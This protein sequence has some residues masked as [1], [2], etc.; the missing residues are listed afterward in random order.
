MVDGTGATADRELSPAAMSGLRV[1]GRHPGTPV[2]LRP[3]AAAALLDGSVPE[4]VRVLN[5]LVS[6]GR[7]WLVPA[8]DDEP[9][10][11][12]IPEEVLRG[13]RD[14]D[15][16]RAAEA[17]R[18][19]SV[20]RLAGWYLHGAVRADRAV[21]AFRKRFGPLY[22]DRRAGEP[23]GDGWSGV[24][25]GLDWLES[26]RHNLRACVEYAGAQAWHDL[27]WQ[28]CEALYGLYITR[29][30]YDDWIA[31]H[32]VG[33]NAATALGD[34]GAQYQIAAQLAYA[35]TEQRDFARAQPVLE[36][37]LRAGRA[38]RLH[39]HEAAALEALGSARL[40]AGEYPAAITYLTQ[41]R[42]LYT[43]IDSAHGMGRTS[44]EIGRARV[45][46]G[47][48]SGAIAQFRSAHALFG[49]VGDVTD[50]ARVL[51]STGE[52]LLL[53]GDPA[54]ARRPLA[55]ARKILARLGRRF[56]EAVALD[57]LGLA[58]QHCGDIPAAREFLSEAVDG[59][60]RT[61]SERAAALRARL[62]ELPDPGPDAPWPQ[63]PSEPDP[64]DPDGPDAAGFPGPPGAA[65][66]PPPGT[67]A[68][69]PQP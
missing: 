27:A 20:R 25:A 33:L 67:P 47:A 61:G 22:R 3:D 53:S 41:A 15:A 57:L 19:A 65:A 45:R 16:A 46:L 4:A 30:H 69:Q 39:V 28:L 29:R 8:A 35:Y 63:H 10:R 50:Q 36:H 40:A 18:E 17:D 60:E 42:A 59:Y 7:A 2:T 1:L 48:F 14:D 43:V 64:D 13:A 52:A 6:A 5:E 31:T 44:Y 68:P 12:T 54:Q 32:T 38:T 34:A 37:A 66:A 62:A 26:E 49:R 24:S 58:A 56:H 23:V 51:I 55:Q 21:N 9:A 11:Y